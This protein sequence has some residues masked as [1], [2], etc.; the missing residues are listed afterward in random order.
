M[1]RCRAVRWDDMLAVEKVAYSE[2]KSA[3]QMAE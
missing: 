1:A 3:G 2:G